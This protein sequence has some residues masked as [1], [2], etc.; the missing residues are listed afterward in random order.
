MK[1]K[2]KYIVITLIAIG[3]LSLVLFFKISMDQHL[4]AYESFHFTDISLEAIP[5]GTYVGSEDGILV[6]ASVEV[7]VRNHRI[8][9]IQLLSHECGT[10][11]PAEVIIEDILEDNSLEVDTISGATYSSNVIKVAVYHALNT[12]VSR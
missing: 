6:K 7:T 5:D 11:K 4:S 12:A 9:A 1:L 2:K 8:E 10:G 3:I